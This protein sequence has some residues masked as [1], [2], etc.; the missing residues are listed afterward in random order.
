VRVRKT[1]SNARETR[2]RARVWSL[3]DLMSSGGPVVAS[4][5]NVVDGVGEDAVEELLWEV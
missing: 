5:L 3:V 4:G 2:R 1:W